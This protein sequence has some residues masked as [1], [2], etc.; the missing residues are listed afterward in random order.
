MDSGRKDAEA[1]EARLA[2]VRDEHR[3]LDESIALAVT[4]P[5]FDELALRRLKKRKLV[6]KDLIARFDSARFP[7][8]IA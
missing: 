1:N 8:I 4:S 7:D 5:N 3:D 2:A 6:L